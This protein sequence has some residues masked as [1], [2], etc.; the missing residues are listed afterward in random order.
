MDLA[1]ASEHHACDIFD[2]M[3]YEFDV[4]VIVEDR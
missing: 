2:A 1:G 4:A 3:D